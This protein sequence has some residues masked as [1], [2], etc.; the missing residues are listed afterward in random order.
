VKLPPLQRAVLVAIVRDSGCWSARELA[1]TTRPPGPAFDATDYRGWLARRD[2]W[3][4]EC[5]AHVAEVQRACGRLQEAGFIEKQRPPRLAP[6]FLARCLE[7][8]APTALARVERA[9]PPPEDADD[10]D[11]GD[12]AL[13]DETEPRTCGFYAVLVDVA[14]LVAATIQRRPVEVDDGNALAIVRD[15]LDAHR[16]GQAVTTRDLLGRK[17]GAKGRAYAWLCDVGAIE[18]PSLRWPTE[19]GIA[20]VSGEE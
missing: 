5:E 16:Q 8:G 10:F 15:L 9:E 19:A 11:D 2:A 18:A 1:D 4:A 12:G 3:L 7:Y 6:W 14:D 17:S 20:A 13:D